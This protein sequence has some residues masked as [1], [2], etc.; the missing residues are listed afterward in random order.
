[1]DSQHFIL[2]AV[3]RGLYERLHGLGRS[4]ESFLVRGFGESDGQKQKEKKHSQKNSRAHFRST[5]TR[6]FRVH[7]LPLS[8]RAAARV[9]L[10]AH[11]GLTATACRFITFCIAGAPESSAAGGFRA[12]GRLRR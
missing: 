4:G 6:N 7:L 2:I 5:V 8:R 1:K 10:G 12:A 3:L 9:R 11:A